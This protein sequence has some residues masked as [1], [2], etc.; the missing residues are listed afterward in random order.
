MLC[1]HDRL[2]EQEASLI[3]DVKT[4]LVNLQFYVTAFHPMISQ[5]FYSYS[6]G[7]FGCPFGAKSVFL[8]LTVTA[9]GGQGTSCFNVMMPGSVK[10][11]RQ[12]FSKP[13][14]SVHAYF[15]VIQHSAL[16]GGDC[17]KINRQKRMLLCLLPV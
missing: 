14:P 16:F 3:E 7:G 8:C 9:G 15:D 5:H 17:F 13:V 1:L 10:C 6:C 2:H 12:P 11:Y 4:Y